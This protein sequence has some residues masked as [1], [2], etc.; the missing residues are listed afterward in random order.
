MAYTVFVIRADP[1]R[2]KENN[3]RSS[4][5]AFTL[6]VLEWNRRATAASKGVVGEDE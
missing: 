4:E 1:P 3:L 5:K 2:F 6:H